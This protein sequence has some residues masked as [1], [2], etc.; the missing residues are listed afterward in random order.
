MQ[1]AEATCAGPVFV[2]PAQKLR[3]CEVSELFFKLPNDTKLTHFNPFTFISFTPVM[4]IYLTVFDLEY[5]VASR[6]WPIFFCLSSNDDRHGRD[7]IYW[8]KTNMCY[9]LL[10]SINTMLSVLFATEACYTI[11]ENNSKEKPF[12]RGKLPFADVNHHFADEN[13]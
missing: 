7:H 9:F 3:S 5:F 4:Q 6:Q 13:G 10:E 2:A 8:I 12:C 11:K 1:Q